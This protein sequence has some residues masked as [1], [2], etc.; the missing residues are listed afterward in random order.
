MKN[1][2]TLHEVMVLGLCKSSAK[3]GLR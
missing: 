3:S 2:L 1:L